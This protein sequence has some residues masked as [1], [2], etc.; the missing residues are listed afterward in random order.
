[1]QPAVLRSRASDAATIRL[2]RDAIAGD[3]RANK[4]RRV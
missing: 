2:M 4:K 1:M 3:D